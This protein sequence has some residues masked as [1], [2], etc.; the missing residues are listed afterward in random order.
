[1]T[2]A[3]P[4][5]SSLATSLL[6]RLD[7][8][9]NP[10]LVKE[11]RQA[12][13]N[14]V[15]LGILSFF[16]LFQLLML[17]LGVTSS[18]SEQELWTGGVRVFTA[19]QMIL[20]FTILTA[21][22]AYAGTRMLGERTDPDSDL[23][24]LTTLSP[25]S[26]IWGKLLGCLTLGFLV[27]SVCAPFMTLA[28]LLRGIDLL[29]IFVIL[30]FDLLLMLLTM[31]FAL[32]SALLPGGLL[33]KR[34]AAGIGFIGLLLFSY[35]LM[36]IFARSI[37]TGFGDLLEA[38]F[39]IVPILGLFGYFL[40]YSIALVSAPSANSMFIVRTFMALAVL[41]VALLLALPITTLAGLTSSRGFPAE[42]VPTLFVYCFIPF[43]CIQI[44]VSVCERDHWG[45]RIT[46]TIP[47]WLIVRGIAFLFYSGSA[48]GVLYS[49][50]M[51]AVTFAIT[52][53]LAFTAPSTVA[54]DTQDLFPIL[55]LVLYTYCFCI[56]GWLLRTLVPPTQLRPENT[57][58][59]VAI[60]LGVL[61]ALP[62]VIAYSIHGDRMN[63]DSFAWWNLTNPFYFISSR[64]TGIGHR[65]SHDDVLSVFLGLWAAGV[66]FLAL[67]QFFGQFIRF[68]RPRAEV[69][70]ERAQV[71]NELPA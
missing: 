65:G 51:I 55:I 11:L 49:T 70:Y 4:L 47:R 29:T 20:L 5:A 19:Q 34:I 2:S 28:Y 36:F 25:A 61:S 14:R 23:M 37:E 64:I 58:V 1:M 16:L 56:T 46:R 21:L 48:G 42:V 13:K 53:Y 44:L 62:N 54:Y 22:P 8:H 35:F 12:V 9:L 17:V 38:L 40:V 71:I 26:I 41:V 15:V 18:S 24:F 3:P 66:T 43:F 57:W 31:Q 52:G 27:F 67:P 30:A 32:F 33:I 59:L 63:Q 50:G 7:N 45:P 39:L 68:A 6:E 10:I 69:V 60:L